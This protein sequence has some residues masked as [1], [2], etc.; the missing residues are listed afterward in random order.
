[1]IVANIEHALRGKPL[2]SIVNGVSPVVRWR[3]GATE[4][5]AQA[6]L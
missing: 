4:S 5:A 2:E 1:M 6:E 3:G